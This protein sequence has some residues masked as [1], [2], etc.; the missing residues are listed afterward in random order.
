MVKTLCQLEAAG[1]RQQQLARLEESE[2]R[3]QALKMASSCASG[4]RLRKT[5]RS[6]LRAGVAC[7]QA[8]ET[9]KDAA[10]PADRADDESTPT[11]GKSDLMPIAEAALTKSEALL[12]K[13]SQL[14]FECDG[15]KT[16]ARASALSCG[17]E[18][19]GKENKVP[20]SQDDALYWEPE[21]E[22]TDVETPRSYVEEG[23]ERL[24][25]LL[26][27]QKEEG[28]E[29]HGCVCQCGGVIRDSS[30]ALLGQR[31]GRLQSRPSES[32]TGAV[33]CV[34]TGTPCS[35]VTSRS[36]S[37]RSAKLA[38]KPLTAALEASTAKALMAS[39]RGHLTAVAGLGLP[40]P[41]AWTVHCHRAD[42]LAPNVMLLP[43]SPAATSTVLR[44]HMSLPRRLAVVPAV[45][46]TPTMT[47]RRASLSPPRANADHS[48]RRL[49]WKTFAVTSIHHVLAWAD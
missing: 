35:A 30:L 43:P 46:G 33:S 31:G 27:T 7:A 11:A 4:G 14:C 34:S 6:E 39:G 5:R 48:A 49:V 36:P 3:L 22:K 37:P 45:A 26:S 42:A 41:A 40:A 18:A 44:R 13:L 1:A 38:A 25:E 32:P 19:E 29:P 17:S 23:M 15:N 21:A 28:H 16:S 2:R 8:E 20:H 47:A 10:V 24:R 9:Q 12:E